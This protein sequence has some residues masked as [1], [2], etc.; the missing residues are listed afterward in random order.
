MYSNNDFNIDKNDSE[1]L[2]T[3]DEDCSND[4]NYLIKFDLPNTLTS[5]FNNDF[6]NDFKLRKISFYNLKISIK[7]CNFLLIRNIK[8]NVKCDT[9]KIQSIFNRINNKSK[10]N[11]QL[12]KYNYE[13]ITYILNN[14][15]ELKIK[16]NDNFFYK[17]DEEF[18]KNSIKCELIFKDNKIF[19]ENTIVNFNYT[20]ILLLVQ[21][22]NFYLEFNYINNLDKSEIIDIIINCCRYHNLNQI[23]VFQDN[24]IKFKNLILFCTFFNFFDGIKYS[25]ENN[26]HNLNYE[27]SF[28]LKNISDN[29]IINFCEIF[30]HKPNYYN[31]I[32]CLVNCNIKINNLKQFSKYFCSN[33]IHI[34]LSN[35][36]IQH[37]DININNF[38]ALFYKFKIFKNMHSDMFFTFLNKILDT[39]LS[40]HLNNFTIN[41]NINFIDS[42]SFNY[43][44]LKKYC[45]FIEK[46]RNDYIFPYTDITLKKV[47]KNL[48]REIFN[49]KDTFI[50]LKLKNNNFDFLNNNITNDDI[51]YDD[52]ISKNIFDNN[53]LKFIIENDISWSG[54]LYSHYFLSN[55]KTYEEIYDKKK[56]YQ[57]DIDSYKNFLTNYLIKFNN[58]DIQTKKI[59]VHELVS[60]CLTEVIDEFL[61]KIIDNDHLNDLMDFHEDDSHIFDFNYIEDYNEIF[62]SDNYYEEL[63]LYL[64]CQYN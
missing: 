33:D 34:Y 36:D 28:D 41:N 53:F 8:F 14:Y 32:A 38:I 10:F 25:W 3:L 46:N 57:Y 21:D 63:K 54:H 18:L 60:H 17:L 42:S 51:I 24:S 52:I 6:I 55:L 22:P 49:Q 11:I 7:V 13:L 35:L 9:N 47:N 16:T 27:D 45:L 39:N 26:N 15:N 12:C 44:G 4:N 62:N 23:K 31:N 48:L 40:N 30:T 58:I 20:N 59:I 2:K 64:L 19:F 43:N 29:N 1:F 5:N 37:D 56:N 50:I 61:E